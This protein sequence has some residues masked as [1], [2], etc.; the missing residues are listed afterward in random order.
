MKAVRH[1][2]ETCPAKKGCYQDCNGATMVRDG[3]VEWD[4]KICKIPIL[5][6]GPG[7]WSATD[8]C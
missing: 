2:D 5:S 1:A 6:F 7:F 3:H 8:L 4:Y